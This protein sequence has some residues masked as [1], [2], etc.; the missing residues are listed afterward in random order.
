MEAIIDPD[1]GEVTI[2]HDIPG[3]FDSYKMTLTPDDLDVGTYHMLN[4]KGEP[5]YSFQGFAGDADAFK[6]GL[7]D[8]LSNAERAT[9]PLARK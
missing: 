3:T 2:K 1:A 4:S 9:R 6:Q 8:A 7:S 5:G